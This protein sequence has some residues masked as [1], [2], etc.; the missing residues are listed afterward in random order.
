MPPLTAFWVGPQIWRD[1]NRSFSN[2]ARGEQVSFVL[3]QICGK[4]FVLRQIWGRAVVYG[5][6]EISAIG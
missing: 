6:S 3:R 4:V 1:T 5:P 2:L